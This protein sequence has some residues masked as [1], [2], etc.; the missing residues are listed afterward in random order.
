MDAKIALTTDFDG[1]WTGF[2]WLASDTLGTKPFVFLALIQ[3]KWFE[4]LLVQEILASV[5]HFYFVTA[6]LR[7]VTLLT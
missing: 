2:A 1:A 3:L 5:A 7:V 6:Y 4:A